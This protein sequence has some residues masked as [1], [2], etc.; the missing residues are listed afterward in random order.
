VPTF[1]K[2]DGPTHCVTF[3]R[4]F[5]T[6]IIKADKTTQHD[7]DQPPINASDTSAGIAAHGAAHSAANS[8]ANMQTVLTADECTFY[9]AI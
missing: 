7:S 6:T 5:G 1:V 3:R 8:E 4:A 9:S 2:T